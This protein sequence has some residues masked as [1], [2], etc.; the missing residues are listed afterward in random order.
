MVSLASNRGFKIDGADNYGK[1]PFCR[2]AERGHETVVLL[3]LQKRANPNCE[4][5]RSRDGILRSNRWRAYECR[6]AIVVVWSEINAVDC[7]GM[8]TLHRAVRSSH[9]GLIRL[10]FERKVDSGIE[11]I[12]GHTAH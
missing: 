12:N 11:D 9:A 8:T 1:T 6:S 3:L 10:L 5:H 7:F 4:G 2:V